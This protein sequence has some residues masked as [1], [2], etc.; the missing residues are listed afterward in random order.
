MKSKYKTLFFIAALFFSNMVVA[1]AQ[2]VEEANINLK[3]ALNNMQKIMR[4]GNSHF[5]I[6]NE[7]KMGLC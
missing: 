1:H 3:D 7:K 2:S 5:C 6:K 4:E